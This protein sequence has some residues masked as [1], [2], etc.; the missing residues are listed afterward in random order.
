ML[1]IDCINYAEVASVNSAIFDL[2]AMHKKRFDIGRD[3]IIREC[4]RL[5]ASGSSIVDS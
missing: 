5:F 1:L 2:Y 3:G 4:G